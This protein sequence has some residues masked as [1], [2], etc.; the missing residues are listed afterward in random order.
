MDTQTFPIPGAGTYPFHTT[1]NNGVAQPDE[2]RPLCSGYAAA[3][4]ATCNSEQNNAVAQAS[5]HR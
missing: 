2:G 3:I 1:N 4:I 5:T